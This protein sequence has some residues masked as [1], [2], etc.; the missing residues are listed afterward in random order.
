MQLCTNSINNK[1]IYEI[2]GFLFLHSWVL[3][4]SIFYMVWWLLG[5]IQK[6]N[7]RAYPDIYL[8]GKKAVQRGFLYL[9]IGF[10]FL[11]GATIT[12]VSLYYKITTH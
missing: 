3:I 10:L 2:I 12:S 7:P 5:D 11:V 1:Y 9:I 6:K 4:F 8:V